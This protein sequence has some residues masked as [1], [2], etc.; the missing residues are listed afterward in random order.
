MHKFI[1]FNTFSPLITVVMCY[2]IVCVWLEQEKGKV[3]ENKSQG[4]Y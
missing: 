4:D 2:S 3:R 1:L